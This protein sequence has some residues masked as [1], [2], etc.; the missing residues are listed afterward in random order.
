MGV[1]GWG[2]G[3]KGRKLTSQKRR[4]GMS[5]SNTHPHNRYNG[6]PGFVKGADVSDA[7][8][9]DYSAALTCC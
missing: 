5:G 3:E 4:P 9:E 8:A 7:G 6:F 2:E 1:G